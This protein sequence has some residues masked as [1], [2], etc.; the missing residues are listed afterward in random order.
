MEPLSVFHPVII[1][2][3]NSKI[4]QLKRR[5][6]FQVRPGE[7]VYAQVN[8]DKKRSRGAGGASIYAACGII[9][10]PEYVRFVEKEDEQHWSQ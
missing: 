1:P 9:C 4:G 5:F 7:P 10:V 8:R 2:G 3:F 6:M